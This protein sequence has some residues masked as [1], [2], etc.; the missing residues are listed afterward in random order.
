MRRG[1]EMFFMLFFK[2]SNI[3]KRFPLL[4]ISES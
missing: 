3:M 1:K 4:L 2:V